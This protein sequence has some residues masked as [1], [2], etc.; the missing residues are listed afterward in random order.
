MGISFEYQ[1]YR[2]YASVRNYK[3][4]GRALTY[5]YILN[6]LGFYSDILSGS[7]YNYGIQYH[8]AGYSIAFQWVPKG[9]SGLY[10][11]GRY[12]AF[13]NEMLRGHNTYGA[14]SRKDWQAEG[15]YR[16]AGEHFSYT[17]KANVD[18]LD[19]DGAEYLY[20]VVVVDEESRETDYQLLSKLPKYAQKEQHYVLSLLTTYA[21]KGYLLS[22]EAAGGFHAE[23]ETY[24]KGTYFTRIHKG[25]G[26]L[27]LQGQKFSAK[28][29]WELTLKGQMSK[30]I[31][32]EKH[33]LSP[34]TEASR[35]VVT[36]LLVLPDYDY[37]RQHLYRVNA[38]LSLLLPVKKDL[39]A[40][41][42]L[43]YERVAGN[44]RWNQYLAGSVGLFF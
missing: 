22:A 4:D 23:E 10:L 5:F 19:G 38:S 7:E 17:L 11:M 35:Y 30:N 16:M 31:A 24:Q 29:I 6:G 42:K 21:D 34:D 37:K 28:A 8:G 27:A 32:A 18:Y 1:R 2:Q 14:Y 25:V 39:L 26:H 41:L 44:H 15:G 36:R 13:N 43:T 9:Q 20:K 33:L 12:A 40:N 3:D